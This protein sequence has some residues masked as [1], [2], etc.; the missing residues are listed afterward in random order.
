VQIIGNITIHSNGAI[1]LQQSADPQITGTLLSSTHD[2][3]VAVHL[4]VL[5]DWHSHSAQG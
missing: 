5:Q 2:H 4:P 1:R 3:Q